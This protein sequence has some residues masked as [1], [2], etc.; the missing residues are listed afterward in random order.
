LPP[1]HRFK[2]KIKRFA[3]GR[4]REANRPRQIVRSATLRRCF[5]RNARDCAQRRAIVAPQLPAAV[6]AVANACN[7]KKAVCDACQRRL[8]RRTFKKPANE[9]IEVPNQSYRISVQV[10]LFVT[11]CKSVAF[12]AASACRAV[13]S[14]AV[15]PAALCSIALGA[16]WTCLLPFAMLRRWFS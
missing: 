6:K 2:N 13:K 4:T 5:G 9:K 1:L 7:K 8:E 12:C 14:C 3:R 15:A 10:I 11:F 16:A